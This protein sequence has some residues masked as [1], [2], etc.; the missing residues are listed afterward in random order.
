MALGPG[1]IDVH[2]LPLPQR[3]IKFVL[4]TAKG[5]D[6]DVQTKTEEQ[7]KNEHLSALTLIVA[8]TTLRPHGL[9]GRAWPGLP[10]PPVMA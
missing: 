7:L 9:N 1:N 4:E 6:I 2:P 10:P 8:R 3:T 5:V